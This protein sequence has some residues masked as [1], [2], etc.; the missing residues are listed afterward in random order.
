MQ[1]PFWQSCEMS[2]ILSLQEYS[3]ERYTLV[4]FWKEISVVILHFCRKWNIIEASVRELHL[5]ACTSP[6]LVSNESETYRLDPGICIL[7]FTFISK[8]IP[9]FFFPWSLSPCLFHQDVISI[10]F[11][12]L[13]ELLSYQDVSF[14]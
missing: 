5:L 7:S 11:N 6:L 14:C 12:L 2:H 1:F 13:K 3:E 4:F 8:L 10:S 9:D